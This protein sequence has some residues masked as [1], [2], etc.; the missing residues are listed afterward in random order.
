VP[1]L[2]VEEL[3]VTFQTEDGTIEAVRR[4]FVA[5]DE[6]EIVGLVGESGCGKSSR[7]FRSWI[8]VA[9]CQNTART[10][11]LRR[12]RPNQPHPRERGHLRGGR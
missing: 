3:E 2:E 7:P 11:P 6:A 10:Y 9:E 8:A 12:Q 1:L 4:A 5:A